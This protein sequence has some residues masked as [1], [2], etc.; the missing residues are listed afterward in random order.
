M[1]TLFAALVIALLLAGTLLFAWGQRRIPWLVRTSPLAGDALPSISLIAP[2]LNEQRGIEAAVRSWLALD[3]PALEL[4]VIDDRSTDETPR[5]LAR[6]AEQDRRLR[7]RTIATLPP[8]WLG[9]N[10]ANACGAAEASGEW[11]LFTDADVRFT[12]DVLRRAMAL[13]HSQQLDHLTAAPEATIPGRI[14]GQFPLYFGLLFSF[15]SHPWAVQDPRSK[16]HVGIGAF[17]LVRASAYRAV[18]GHER[19]RLRPDD[20]LKL[21][22]I[23]K[24]AGFRQQFAVGRGCVAVEWYSSWREVRDGLMKNLFAGAEYRPW[25]VVAGSV[26]HVAVLVAPLLLTLFGTGAAQWLGVAGLGLQLYQGFVAAPSFGTARWGGLLLPLFAVFGG[27][28]MW[29]SMWLALKRGGIE[30]R[31]TFYPLDEL[32]RNVV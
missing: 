21:G 6:L 2:A 30:W 14:L 15:F 32:R 7:V 12:P 22:K 5:I 9:K 24:F 27:W 1:L 13:V 16:A 4:I 28:L 10:N 3:Y 31:G 8:G 17:N 11:L 19:I 23:L 29:R 25:F 18:G 20:D 26:S